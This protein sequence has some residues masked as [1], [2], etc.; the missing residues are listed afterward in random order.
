MDTLNF[1]LYRLREKLWVK[2]LLACL[3]SVGGALAAQG[4]DGIDLGRKLPQV[5]ADTI[6]ELLKL[7]AASMLVMATLAVGSMVAAYASA[8]GSATPRAFPLVVA[9][10]VS[11]NALSAFTGAFIFNVVAFIFVSNGYYG[12]V[13]RFTLFVLTVLVLA[14]VR[15]TFVR[16]VDRIARLGRLGM[17]VGTVEKATL[18]ALQARRCTPN[19][20]ARPGDAASH[21]GAPVYCDA[22]GYVQYVDVGKLQACAEALDARIEV[23]GLPG[24]FAAPGR[25]VARVVRGAAGGP[26]P[27]AQQEQ[28]AR[29]FTIGN[30]RKF[31]QDPRFGLIVLSEIASRA[32]SPA[33]NDPGTAIQVIGAFVRLF[34]AWGRPLQADEVQPVLHDRVSVLPLSLEDMFDDAFSAMERDGA[35]V[36]EMGV[37]LQKAFVALGASGHPQMRTLAQTHSR[38]ALER[39]ARRLDAPE[40]LAALAKAART[41]GPQATAQATPARTGQA[42][43]SA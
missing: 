3:L 37:R 21:D 38:R 15:V 26:L 8:A 17:V 5:S 29:C 35:S 32:L 11:Q 34:V 28:V 18:Q 16:W 12:R 24:T 33:V 2:P 41:L 40:D 36:V 25:P 30:D 23:T 42:R 6:E 9:D 22:I 4:A 10:D 20:R 13:G 7:V 1:L 31:D 39:A 27:P 14:F 43:T 19:L